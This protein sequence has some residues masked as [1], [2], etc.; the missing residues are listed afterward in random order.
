M[1][2]NVRLGFATNSSSTHSVIVL[3]SKQA[4]DDGVAHG[5][6]GWDYWTAASSSA[7]SRYLAHLIRQNLQGRVGPDIAHTVAKAWT[8][9]PRDLDLSQDTGIDHQSEVTL[10]RDWDGRA[11]LDKEFIEHLAAFL[12]RED[13]VILG[14]N[15][16]DKIEHELCAH[17]QPTSWNRLW[18]ER[19]NMEI[20]AKRDGPHWV[21]FDRGT[22]HKIR[23]ALDP[24]A[25]PYTKAATPELVDI[26]ITDFCPYG[27]TYCYQD[28][29]TK[30]AHADI[31]Y[32][33]SLSYSLAEMRVFEV[34]LGGGEPTMHPGFLD[35]IETFRYQGIVPNFTTRNMSF[36][37]DPKSAGALRD[38]IGAFALSVD[39]EMFGRT[40]DPI[41]EYARSGPLGDKMTVQYVIGSGSDSFFHHL[42]EFCGEN[43]IKLVLLGA[44]TNGRGLALADDPKR[45]QTRN[46]LDVVRSA[47]EGMYASIG[48][49]TALAEQSADLL[50]EAEVPSTLYTVREGDFSMYVDAVTRRAAPSSYCDEKLYRKLEVST[51][52]E[53]TS[54]F[55]T[56]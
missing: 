34:A 6:F 48:I 16:N 49:D 10:P 24:E 41:R 56:F 27:C 30:G 11:G 12:M 43:S 38:A 45:H 20:V 1:I 17:G 53:L 51:A 46:W 40:L 25:P 18:K 42:V 15:D 23:F 2:H 32:L 52:D 3:R 7:K 33:R 26:K 50:K 14:G 47:S 13:V 39:E 9:L 29:T 5:H 31:N 54:V 36:L 21:F 4:K 55:R 19:P 37:R 8:G 22:G 35:A 28:S 44:K